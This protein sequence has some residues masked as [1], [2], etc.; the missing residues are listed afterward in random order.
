MF[1]R[2]S[3][4]RIVAQNSTEEVNL[5]D[6]EPEVQ[7]EVEQQEVPT[8]TKRQQRLISR[9]DLLEWGKVVDHEE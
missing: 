7:Q 8:L 4:P 3:I 1:N 9:K 6:R 5:G 2:S